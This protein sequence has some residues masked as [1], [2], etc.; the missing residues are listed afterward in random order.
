MQG[1]W[2][3]FTVPLPFYLLM[4]IMMTMMT[5]RMAINK[6]GMLTF[7]FFDTVYVSCDHQAHPLSEPIMKQMNEYKELLKQSYGPKQIQAHQT[8][9]N[10]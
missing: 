1:Y 7:T 4:T 2:F 3:F 9:H 6:M 10:H 8:I 5:T